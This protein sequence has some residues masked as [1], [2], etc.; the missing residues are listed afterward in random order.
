MPD[1]PYPKSPLAR[2]APLMPPADGLGQLWAPN[3]GMPHPGVTDEELLHLLGLTQPT[4]LSGLMPGDPSAFLHEHRQH[5]VPNLGAGYIP[6]LPLPPVDQADLDA[7]L[8]TPDFVPEG[9]QD[10]AV[11][12]DLRKL[13]LDYHDQQRSHFQREGTWGGQQTGVT[14]GGSAQLL[15]WSNP[16]K[17]PMAFNIQLSYTIDPPSNNV[18]TPTQ[19]VIPPKIAPTP[20][21]ATDD[22][23]IYAR[24]DWGHGNASQT[25]ICDFQGGTQ[26]RLTGSWARVTVLYLPTNLP[27][28]YP[29]QPV[30]MFGTTPTSTTGPSITATAMLGLG[31]PAFVVAPGRFTRKFVLANN[32]QLSFDP[33]P[34]FASAFGYATSIPTGNNWTFTL[35]VNNFEPANGFAQFVSLVNPVPENG[36][37]I[38][39][40][41]RFMSVKNAS[42]VTAAMQL[43]YALML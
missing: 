38:P 20:N 4:D 12:Q 9:F 24:V 5:P 30:Q 35:D 22:I 13:L 26:L 31:F 25:A 39:S 33:I 32:D 17:A 7:R 16:S 36:L 28:G 14:P 2:F 34:P 40:G 29:H 43:V 42:G 10:P 27:S 6:D 19:G 37:P 1:F 18:A 15:M 21:L 8:P 23:T 3:Y 41:S 11:R